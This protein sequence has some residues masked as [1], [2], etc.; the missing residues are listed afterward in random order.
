MRLWVC[1]LEGV[2]GV[3]ALWLGVMFNYDRH[4]D[5]VLF[6]AALFVTCAARRLKIVSLVFASF[7]SCFCPVFLLFCF[8]YRTTT[9][10]MSRK[11]DNIIKM[12]VLDCCSKEEEEE[13][14]NE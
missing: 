13:E 6:P 11:M 10:K 7:V 2:G 3:V 1:P 12:I 4:D 8:F 5:V 14:E 9:E